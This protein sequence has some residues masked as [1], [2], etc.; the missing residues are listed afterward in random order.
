MRTK[1]Y[2]DL[3][4]IDDLSFTFAAMQKLTRPGAFGTSREVRRYRPAND[5]SMT[6]KVVRMVP[7]NGGCSTT[8]GRVP[9]SVSRVVLLADRAGKTCD[10]RIAAREMAVAA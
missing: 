10:I 7:Y 4:R 3:R 2:D 8:S 5:N 1:L 9:V 6:G